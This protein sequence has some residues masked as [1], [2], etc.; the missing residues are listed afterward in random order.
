[1]TIHMILDTA[2]RASVIVVVSIYCS[3]KLNAIISPPLLDA[4]VNTW[5]VLSNSHSQDRDPYFLKLTYY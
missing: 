5:P 2:S 1:M 3:G 4:I